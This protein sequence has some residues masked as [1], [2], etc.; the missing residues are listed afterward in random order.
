MFDVVIVG[1]GPAGLNAALVLGRAR[2]RVLL[3][4]DGAPRNA[5]AQE[6]HGFL[7]RDG[8]APADLRRLAREQLDTY[9]GVQLRDGRVTSAGRDRNGFL[10]TLDDGTTVT[11]RALLLA[12]GLVDEL[13]PID[14][15]AACWGRSVFNCPYCDGWEV[16]DQPLA[17][18]GGG[19]HGLY[20][21]WQLTGWSRDVA[22]CTNG[23]VAVDDEARAS[24][25][26][27]GIADARAHLRALGVTVREE[28]IRRVEAT[29]GLLER[30][31]LA[32]GSALPCRA[33]FLHPPHRQHADLPR[34][35][36][37][38]IAP[39]GLVLVNDLGQT[40]VPGVYA[41]G[42]MARR[43]SQLLPGATVVIAAATGAT[44]AVA[45]DHEL[46]GINLAAWRGIR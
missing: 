33:A 11:A 40:D 36:G 4:D 38:A 31:V 5:V 15:L 3:C 45:I 25:A 21:A 6:M 32:D 22:L 1:G 44:A 17:V 12:T 28:P 46:R 27:L 7:S 8:L 10:I 42:D 26:A 30:I 18:L 24:L 29:E 34:Q 37:C 13:P 2:R 20:L 9:D 35:L 39:D 14:G 41:A 43:P 19:V 23:A 16:R